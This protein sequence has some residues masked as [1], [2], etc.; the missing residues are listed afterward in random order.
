MNKVLFFHP[1]EFF[2][3]LDFFYG[4]INSDVWVVVDHVE[5]T[6]RSRQSRCRVKSETGI[7][8]LPVSV[9]RPCNKPVCSMMINNTYPWRRIFLRLLKI[10]YKDAPF[11]D[12]YYYTV[13]EY[14]ESPYVLLETLTLETNLWI[15]ELLGK[16]VDYVRTS[17]LQTCH[18]KRYSKFPMAKIIPV[19]LNK[20]GGELFS[21]VFVH[22]KYPQVVDPFEKDCSILDSLFCVGPEN[23][24]EMIT[25]KKPVSKVNH[26]FLNLL[27]QK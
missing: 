22:P 19:L 3:P 16:K 1:P 12:E 7:T 27:R 8:L 23:I 9:V 11:F 13:K 20:L 24:R 25:I 21:E 15:A 5:Y 17:E 4:L 10:Y 26:K 6:T 18:E 14:V 2:P